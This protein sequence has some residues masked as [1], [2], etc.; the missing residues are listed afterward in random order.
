MCKENALKPWELSTKHG[1]QQNFATGMTHA[2]NNDGTYTATLTA[3]DDKPQS[4][5]AIATINVQP[6]TPTSREP[7]LEITL[8]SASPLSFSTGSEKIFSTISVAVR[9]NGSATDAKVKLFIRE[10]LTNENMASPP[11]LPEDSQTIGTGIETQFSFSGIDFSSLNLQPGSYKLVAE[12]SVQGQP[13]PDDKEEFEFTVMTLPSGLGSI[14][15]LAP[16]LLPL[17]AAIVL[18]ALSRKR[19]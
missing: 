16:L 13:L 19:E 1:Q 8:F 4:T 5:T 6:P 14:P 9:N 11:A 7:E 3:T 18:F 12:A 2:Y 15:E 10:P 17:L